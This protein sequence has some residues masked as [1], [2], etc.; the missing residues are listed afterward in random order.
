M[1]L[2]CGMQQEVVTRASGMLIVFCL[3]YMYVYMYVHM[4]VLQ[5][6]IYMYVYVYM[7]MYVHVHCTC[8]VS[9][10]RIPPEAAVSS[11]KSTSG[12]ACLTLSLGLIDHAWP[13]IDLFQDSQRDS[14]ISLVTIVHYACTGICGY[15][16]SL[17]HPLV[18]NGPLLFSVLFLIAQ[19]DKY[20][21]TCI[22]TCCT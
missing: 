18:I 16:L 8:I 7:Y 6:H 3:T 10:V 2:S 12:V 5:A 13:D 15:P 21:L 4:Y 14:L 9:C 1:L 20:S 22:W 11:E 17:V 19:V